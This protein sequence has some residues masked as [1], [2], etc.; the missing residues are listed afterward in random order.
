VRAAGCIAVLLYLM[1]SGVLT[2][3]AWLLIWGGGCGAHQKLRWFIGWS[4][5]WVVACG[6]LLCAFRGLVHASR[7]AQRKQR[8]EG[9]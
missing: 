5:L 7:E 3:S 9:K 2:V 6:L 8:T 4:E 1:L